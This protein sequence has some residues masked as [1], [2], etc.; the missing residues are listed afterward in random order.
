MNKFGFFKN[1]KLKVYLFFCNEKVTG[2]K[3]NKTIKYF[4]GLS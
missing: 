4:I 2:E 1:Y 3:K